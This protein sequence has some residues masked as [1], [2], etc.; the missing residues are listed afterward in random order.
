MLDRLGRLGERLLAFWFSGEFVTILFVA[1][2][3]GGFIW[4]LL[5]GNGILWSLLRGFAVGVAMAFAPFII[6]MVSVPIM[7]AIMMVVSPVSLAIFFLFEWL[8]R[9]R[10]SKGQAPTAR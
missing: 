7:I 8:D 2:W 1:G 3:T 6:A 9:R 5:T 10:D 4:F